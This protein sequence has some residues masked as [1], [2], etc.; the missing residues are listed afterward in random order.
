[1]TCSGSLRVSQQHLAFVARRPARPGG[2]VD[3]LPPP[4]QR[5]QR[6]RGGR[7]ASRLP[8]WSCGAATAAGSGG[9]LLAVCMGVGHGRSC[10]AI[11]RS[12]CGRGE[13]RRRRTRHDA[14]V[15]DTSLRADSP[16][17]GY[18][19][20]PQDQD[21]S[22]EEIRRDPHSD[23]EDMTE[24]KSST[25][26]PTTMCPSCTS[27]YEHSVVGG[28]HRTLAAPRDARPHHVSGMHGAEAAARAAARTAQNDRW[29][30]PY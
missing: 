16:A 28:G 7:V 10:L 19:P 23:V 4:W 26:I 15:G 1:M 20:R 8:K 3:G 18:K 22:G 9:R 21:D 12:N 2:C 17:R 13:Q 24:G 25:P 14:S 29:P 6:W 27:A 30:W 11:A 5:L